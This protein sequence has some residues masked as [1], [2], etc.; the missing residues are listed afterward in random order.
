ME[1]PSVLSPGSFSTFVAGIAEPTG[2]PMF[3]GSASAEEKKA[4]GPLA[5]E[6]I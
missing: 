1:T 3:T 5:R 2:L 6:P 4:S